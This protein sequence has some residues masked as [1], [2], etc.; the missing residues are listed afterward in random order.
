MKHVKA[1]TLP[2]VRRFNKSAWMT[3]EIWLEFD[4]SLTAETLLIT[5]NCSAHIKI[6]IEFKFLISIVQPMDAGI[7]RSF[8]AHYKSK[9]TVLSNN[10]VFS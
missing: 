10:S 7:I 6:D 3:P 4:S 2:V 9:I 1:A 5:D 8:K